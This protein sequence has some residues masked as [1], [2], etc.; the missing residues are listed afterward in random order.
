MDPFSMASLGLS[1]ISML[2]GG[3][4]AKY[5]A[6]AQA[7]TAKGQVAVSKAQTE[8]GNAQSSVANHLNALNN[9]RQLRQF[10]KAQAALQSNMWAAKDL[11]TATKLEADLRQAEAQGAMQ[12]S[13]AATGTASMGFAAIESSARLRAARMAQATKDAS[14]QLDYNMMQELAG[15]TDS[16]LN[17]LQLGVHSGEVNM[18]QA[19]PQVT[20]GTNYL[21]AVAPLLQQAGRIAGAQLNTTSPYAI[22]N[23]GASSQGLKLTASTGMQPSASTSF[24]NLSPSSMSIW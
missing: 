19:V 8:I 24:F 16:S 11:R 4:V 5:Q 9:K 6:R 15:L 14:N 22:A 2:G 23:L 1:A 17:Q 13:M 3:S 12:A 21:A 18:A 7:A 20:G 10:G